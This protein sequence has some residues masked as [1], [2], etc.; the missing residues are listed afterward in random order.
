MPPSVAASTH[1]QR[2]LEPL[3]DLLPD[4]FLAA[5][6]DLSLLEPDD[7]PP[8][9]LSLSRLLPWLSP[10]FVFGIALLP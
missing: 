6:D 9:S 8:P 2:L 7:F 1:T 3:P 5:E 10:C 4:D